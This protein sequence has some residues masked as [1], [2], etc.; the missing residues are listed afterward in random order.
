MILLVDSAVKD[1]QNT[2]SEKNSKVALIID[3]KL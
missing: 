3:L 1:A 2:I